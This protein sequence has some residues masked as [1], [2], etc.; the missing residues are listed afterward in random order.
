M[1]THLSTTSTESNGYLLMYP[2][3][4]PGATEATISSTRPGD[5]LIFYSTISIIDSGGEQGTLVLLSPPMNTSVSSIQMFRCSL[6]L[7]PQVAV[8]DSQTQQILTVE[9]DFTKTASE[10]MPYTEPE[11]LDSWGLGWDQGW[12]FPNATGNILIDLWELWYQTIPSTGYF[13][14]LTMPSTTTA[15]ASVADIYLI[16]KLNLPA[17]IPIISHS[18][19]WKMLYLPWW[20]PCFGQLTS[21]HIQVGHKHPTYAVTNFIGPIYRGREPPASL[22]E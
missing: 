16:Q 18:M 15:T 17:A 13:L 4:Q 2:S 8:V 1:S 6:S 11:N 14:D 19:I 7:I 9:P 5:G 20:P 3:V 22:S 21:I 12:G 10:W